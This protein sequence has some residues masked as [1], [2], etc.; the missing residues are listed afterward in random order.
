MAKQPWFHFYALK[1]YLEALATQ[2]KLQMAFAA[3]PRKLLIGYKAKSGKAIPAR[4]E[5]FVTSKHGK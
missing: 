1:K 2:C 5:Q 4:G 3:S